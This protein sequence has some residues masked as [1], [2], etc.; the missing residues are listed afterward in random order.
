MV[1]KAQ[2]VKCALYGIVGTSQKTR[3][4]KVGSYP[5]GTYDMLRK[6]VD[7]RAVAVIKD[8]K[9]GKVGGTPEADGVRELFAIVVL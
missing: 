7:T 2:A 3:D 4:T 1:L 6:Y 5:K 9:A 8:L